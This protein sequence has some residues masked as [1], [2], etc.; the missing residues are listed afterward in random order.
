M[1]KRQP[2]R[3]VLGLVAVLAGCAG[4]AASDHETLDH[5]SDS[6]PPPPPPPPRSDGNCPSTCEEGQT[7]DDGRGWLCTCVWIADQVCGGA[8]RQ[9]SPSVLGFVCAPRDGTSDRGDGCPYAQ[10]TDGAPCAGDH[11]CRYAEGCGWNGTDAACLGGRWQ[12]TAFAM[13]PPP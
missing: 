2:M 10:P 5:G 8:Y 12:L 3:V 4:A 6:T 7:C 1:L 13:P 11:A 9:P